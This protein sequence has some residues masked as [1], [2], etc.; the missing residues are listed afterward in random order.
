MSILTRLHGDWLN[1]GS[2]LDSLSRVTSPNYIPTDGMWL[3]ILKSQISD[4]PKDDILRA[5]LK[6]LGMYSHLQTFERY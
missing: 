4:C 1:F 3:S 6:T 5:R 2:F